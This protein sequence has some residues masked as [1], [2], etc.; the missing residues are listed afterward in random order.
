MNESTLITER[1]RAAMEALL[2]QSVGEPVQNTART[3]EAV[4]LRLEPGR[5]TEIIR[6][7]RRGIELQL[8]DRS[9]T[10]RPDSNATD[11]WYKVRPSPDEIG[12][13]FFRLVELDTP[14]VLR[15]F[16]EGRAYVAVLELA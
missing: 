1:T 13:V 14:E 3:R 4:Y 6:R 5:D 9:T 10:P 11:I 8:L 2:D 12:W 16:M 15:P 7:L